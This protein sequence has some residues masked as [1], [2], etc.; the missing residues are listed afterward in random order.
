[1]NKIVKILPL[2]LL[3]SQSYAFSLT[4][5]TD[6]WRKLT[7]GP[8]SDMAAP[9]LCD[10]HYPLGLPQPTVNYKRHYL[11]RNGYA[12]I[13]S[14]DIKTPEVVAY[15]LTPDKYSGIMTSL[16][17]QSFIADPQLENPERIKSVDYKDSGMIPLK[18]VSGPE[19]KYD[20][21]AVDESFFFSNTAPATP[22]FVMGIWAS[23][24]KRV[25]KWTNS[26][27]KLYIYTGPIYAKKPIKTI[28][29]KLPLPSHFYKIII[30]PKLQENIVF[31][32]PNEAI[33]PLKGKIK[34][35]ATYDL[36]NYI[37][38]IKTVEKYV[39]LNFLPN[40][41]GYPDNFKEKS[42]GAWALSGN[43]TTSSGQRKKPQ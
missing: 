37:Y 1:M 12:A 20:Q 6:A 25:E 32:I 38:S 7:W 39:H 35:T 29:N 36:E 22:K 3:T 13:Y 17:S 30:D 24:N 33:L 31:I 19:L 21:I 16:T 40:L 42:M 5:I 41:K 27:G 34:K 8:Y 11:C 2:I 14:P 18:M 26:K 10:E 9:G 28:G 4:D 15:Q 23:L 43:E